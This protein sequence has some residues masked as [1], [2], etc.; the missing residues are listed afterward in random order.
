MRGDR[1]IKTIMGFLV[2]VALLLTGFYYVT[3]STYPLAWAFYFACVV[4]PI[5]ALGAWALLGRGRI[6]NYVSARSLKR[7]IL[8][9][10]ASK[11][12]NGINKFSLV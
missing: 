7:T 12:A 9:A 3:I 5:L 10:I 4:V 2:I 6:L 1:L 8:E 11:A